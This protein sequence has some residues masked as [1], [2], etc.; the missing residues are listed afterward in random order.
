MFRAKFYKAKKVL[1]C[2]IQKKGFELPSNILVTVIISVVVLALSITLLYQFMGRGEQ[3]STKVQDGAGTAS[4]QSEGGKV[5]MNP[6]SA[7]LRPGEEK[8][9]EI[10]VMNVG[11]PSSFSIQAEVVQ[12][13]VA[14]KIPILSAGWLTYSSIPFSL[15]NA[16]RHQEKL[17]ITA[18]ADARKGMH[19]IK[20]KIFRKAANLPDTQYGQT[21]T[22]QLE[23]TEDGK[24]QKNKEPVKPKVEQTC[25][26]DLSCDY[27]Y[28]FVP[29]DEWEVQELF[30]VKVHERALFFTDISPFKSKKVG[31]VIMPLDFAKSCSLKNINMESASGHMEIKNCAD[32]YGDKLGIAYERAIGLSSKY[33]GG[34]A[35]FKS[36]AVVASLGHENTN[37]PGL[38]AHEIGHT[39][40]L[41]DEYDWGTYWIQN[42]YFHGNT[43]KNQ[44]PEHCAPGSTECLGNTPVFR[45][46]SG[47]SD[48]IGVCSGNIW[49]SVM[50]FSTGAE[51]G[52]DAT[53][54]YEAIEEGLS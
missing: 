41:C 8:L 43:C 50:G 53:G 22:F 7:K 18:P 15:E 30:D 51:C 21:L 29:L 14:K 25:L 27:Y 34:K 5:A 36:K 2:V 39:Y 11:N 9:A 17:L 49:Y 3:M 20:V 26:N 47:R 46:Y 23:V 33:D 40:F 6:T 32:K 31:I 12:Q 24:V 13:E 10:S 48:V 54:G 1:L 19:H 16:A 37:R 38:V 28:V 52:Y 44:W 35:F 4:A 45:A 42:R